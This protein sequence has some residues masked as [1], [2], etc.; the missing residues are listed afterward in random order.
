MVYANIQ[1][2][3]CPVNGSNL[4]MKRGPK[5]KIDTNRARIVAYFDAESRRVYSP[6]ALKTALKELRELT[7]TSV[8]I[9]EFSSFLTEKTFLEEITIERSTHPE[10]P[11]RRYIWRGAS[12]Y[13]IGLSLEKGY[14]SHYSAVTLHGLTDAL[15]RTIYIN[16]EQSAKRPPDRDAMT[17]AGINR[18]FASKQRETNYICDWNDWRFA[19]LSGKHTGGLEVGL[20][21][22]DE[23]P[24][25][26]T[27][28]ERTLID[29]AVR[30]AYSGGVHQV[31][32]AYKRAKDRAAIGTLLATLKSLDYAYPYHQAIGFY[33]QRAGYNPAQYERLRE[34]GLEHDFYLAHDLRDQ[35]YVESWRLHVP[36]GF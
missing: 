17:Q 16:R 33:L 13:E 18:A 6:H 34:L 21:M 3:K 27:Q 11:F 36:K 8:G 4:A 12:A 25:P 32:E 1:L 29:I 5:S 15:P 2:N 31:L 30:P 19:M 10:E 22:V 28:I 23:Q 20:A 35:E 9:G 14:L 26:V 7:A 24:L